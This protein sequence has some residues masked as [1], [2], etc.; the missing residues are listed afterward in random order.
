[1]QTGEDLKAFRALLTGL[2][3]DLGSVIQANVI[4]ARATID[5]FARRN[6]RIAFPRG[7]V[8]ARAL[9]NEIIAKA[10]DID[11]GDDASALNLGI[12]NAHAAFF[13]CCAGFVVQ[14]ASA[15]LHT[16]ASA[17]E[18]GVTLRQLKSKDIVLFREGRDGFAGHDRAPNRHGNGQDAPRPRREHGALGRLLFDHATIG[19]N[20]RE[21]AIRDVE[22]GFG[23]IEHHFRRDAAR[24]QL[25]RAV[26]VGLRLVALRLLRF[27][28]LVQRLHLQ[29]QLL[30][31]DERDFGAPHDDIALFD[32][33][34]RDR[35]ADSRPGDKLMNGLNR[36]DHGL[37]IVDRHDVHGDLRSAGPAGKGRAEHQNKAGASSHQEDEIHPH[38]FPR[39]KTLTLILR[40]YNLASM[41][42]V[43]LAPKA[44]QAENFLK[45]LANRHRLMILC[46]LHKGETGVSALQKALGLTQSSLSQHLARLREDELVTTRRESQAI[47][48]SLANA[49]VSRAIALLYE[50]FC[51]EECD[52]KQK[53]KKAGQKEGAK[54]SCSLGL[55]K[56]KGRAT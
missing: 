43:K 2:D 13:T 44:V 32:L 27:D 14:A 7:Q 54:A 46:E 6:D 48:Y 22:H 1:M 37:E 36:C 21:I 39:G 29:K 33:Q 11:V 49:N 17:H 25:L 40:I 20:R 51:A 24:K 23:L 12:D 5:R 53:R 18:S 3:H 10:F 28:S 4:D 15:N 16:I 41:N 47:F 52:A 56:S 34:R 42:L 30:I 45:A 38:R 9:S 19:A 55:T 35:A 8:N 50:L 26:E 31:S